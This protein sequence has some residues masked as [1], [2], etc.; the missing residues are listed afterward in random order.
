M[1]KMFLFR[2]P[3]MGAYVI[4]GSCLAGLCPASC[5]AEEPTVKAPAPRM[6]EYCKKHLNSLECKPHDVNEKLKNINATQEK[7]SEKT[8]KDTDTEGN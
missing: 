6:S 8:F 3:K 4:L 5:F 7:A 1:V 2:F